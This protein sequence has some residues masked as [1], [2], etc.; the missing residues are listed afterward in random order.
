L[1]LSRSTDQSAHA[2]E[3]V[4]RRRYVGF[5]NALAT[6]TGS[7]DTAHDAVQE[8]FARAL[9]ARKTFRGGSLEA[10]VFTARVVWPITWIDLRYEDGTRTRLA[11]GHD[12]VVRFEVG[13]AHYA[14]GHRLVSAVALDVSGRIIERQ[15][16]EP[17][18]PGVY[19]CDRRIELARGILACP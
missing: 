15:R 9:K 14:R 17:T 16:F 6:V 19:P 2:L 10:V 12:G 1:G 5:R 3:D 13:H 18:A 4:Y 7:Y 8:G 11:T